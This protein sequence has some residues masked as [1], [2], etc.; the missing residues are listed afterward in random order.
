MTDFLQLSALGGVNRTSFERLDTQTTPGIKTDDVSGPS[1]AE[2]LQ[3]SGS[4]LVGSLEKAEMTSMK[5]MAGEAGAYEVASAIME[6]E[7]Q[8]KMATAVRDK[9]VQSFLDITRMQI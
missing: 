5:G 2:T 7:Q 1:F 4:K 6:A 9:I 8:L 3:E